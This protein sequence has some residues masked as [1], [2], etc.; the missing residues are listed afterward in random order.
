MEYQAYVRI[1]P[2]EEILDPQGKATLQGLETMGFQQ[3]EAVR[4]GKL[5]RLTIQ[6]ADEATARQIAEEAA[7]KLLSNPIV[8]SYSL[9]LHPLV[10][11]E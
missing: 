8:E 5:I 6:A 3:I 1:L 7:N 4:V 2:R 9:E 10:H 11:N